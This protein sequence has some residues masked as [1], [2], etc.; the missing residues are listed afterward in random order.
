MGK[1]VKLI[2]ITTTIFSLLGAS[3]TLAAKKKPK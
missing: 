1:Y 2:V 3:V